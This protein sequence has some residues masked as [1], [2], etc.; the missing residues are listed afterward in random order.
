[1]NA[2]ASFRSW[3]NRTRRQ[4]WR[5]LFGRMLFGERSLGV[6]R[7]ATR[8]S[9]TVLI[10]HEDRLQLADDVFVGH[11]VFIE[12]SAGV[13]VD[14]GV[15]ITNFVSIVSHATARSVRVA[16]AL[17][18]VPLLA[19]APAVGL[20]GD[21]RAP[22]A[23]GAHSFIGPHSTLEAGAQ[24]GRCSLVASHSRVRGVQPDFAILAGSP[25]QVVGDVRQGDSAWL[26][27]LAAEHGLDE[28]AL[29]EAYTRWLRAVSAQK[30]S[31]ALQ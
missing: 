4:L 30:G 6:L 23:I 16:K 2:A 7:P 8:L 9:P 20:A 31:N 21:T 26:A 3:F 22:I 5:A 1:M 11:F 29:A 12:A 24:L 10:E 15:Q 17:S 19:A 13:R 25:A 18:G 14:T 28:A 27:R